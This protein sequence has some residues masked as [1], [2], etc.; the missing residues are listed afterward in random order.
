M[1]TDGEI[2]AL[3]AD[4]PYRRV[5]PDEPLTPVVNPESEIDVADVT[6]WNDDGGLDL[7]SH[8]PV[9]QRDTSYAFEGGS[10]D[11]MP[12]KGPNSSN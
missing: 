9:A 2:R 12:P 4:H 3:P 8:V 6:R 5:E 7:G 10:P 1:L 11:R